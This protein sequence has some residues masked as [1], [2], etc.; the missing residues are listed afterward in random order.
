MP[1]R[2]APARKTACPDSALLYPRRFES[3][4]IVERIQYHG[5]PEVPKP[6]KT[7]EWQA[8]IG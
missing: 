2:I 7:T 3:F 6:V 4:Q 1:V 5:S 8:G